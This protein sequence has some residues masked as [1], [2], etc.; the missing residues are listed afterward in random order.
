MSYSVKQ[1]LLPS[2]KYP[3]KS[4]YPMQA[5]YIT[6]HNTANDAS[7]ANEVAFMLRNNNEVSYHVAI[8]DKEVIQVIPFDRTAW[9]AGDGKGNGNMKSIGIEICYSKS[10]GLRYTVAEENAVQY[11]AKLLHERG[12]GVNR[13]KKHQDWSGKYCPH[14]ILAENRWEAF[15]QRIDAALK[16]LKQQVV[17]PTKQPT[18]NISSQYYV[19]QAGD[20]LWSIARNHKVT[21]EQIKKL[22]GL[23]TDVI[24]PGQKLKIE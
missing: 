24:K 7:A 16:K 1:N 5:Q 20:S 17:K 4:P 19:V 14:R 15:K 2:T 18:K 6:V 3:I 10:G 21:V 8:D 9:H 23:K 13:V 12:W 22:N 11:I